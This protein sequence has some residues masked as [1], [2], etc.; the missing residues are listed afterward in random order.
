MKTCASPNVLKERPR[1]LLTPIANARHVF[2]SEHMTSR[3][4]DIKTILGRKSS[5]QLLYLILVFPRMVVYYHSEN[6]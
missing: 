3:S 1:D 4:V 6:I 2:I 5:D